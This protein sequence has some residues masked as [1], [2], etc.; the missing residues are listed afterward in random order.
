MSKGEMKLSGNW[1]QD[2]Y[3]EYLKA[4]SKV[5]NGFYGHMHGGQKANVVKNSASHGTKHHNPYPKNKK[6][7]C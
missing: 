4:N 5:D 7:V 3:M 6:G 2:S 1:T